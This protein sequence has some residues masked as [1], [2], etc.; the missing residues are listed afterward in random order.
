L[1]RLTCCEMQQEHISAR[2]AQ[3][4]SEPLSPA[5]PILQ[6][7]NALQDA[8][9]HLAQQNHDP[10]L[11]PIIEKVNTL[12]ASLAQHFDYLSTAHFGPDE[13]VNAQ[14][15]ERLMALAGPAT[16][17]ELLD[18]LQIDLKAAQHALETAN[19]ERDWDHLR[20]QCHVL[21]AIAGSIGARRVQTGAEDL[22][23]A[24]MKQDVRSVSAIRKTLISHLQSLL[25]FVREE[26]QA[27]GR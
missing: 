19:P 20:S 22:H 9:T 10:A 3:A 8:V 7:L 27:R 23:N 14:V 24:A 1:R 11:Q 5:S 13:I 6:Q 21:V 15:F 17:I 26:R 4:L 12:C 16:A 2:T 25:S 18:Q